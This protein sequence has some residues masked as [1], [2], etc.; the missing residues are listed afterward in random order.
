VVG[1]RRRG[2][3]QAFVQLDDGRGRVECAFFA[4]AWNQYAALLTRDRV[5]VVEG[6]LREDEFSGGFALRARRCWDYAQLCQ[7][8]AQRLS[9]KLDLREDEALGRFTHLLQGHAGATP[10]LVEAITGGAIG[11]LS[12]NGG[13]GVRSDAALPSLVRGLPGVRAVRLHLN[14]PW[15]Q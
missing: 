11:R 12:I 14:R 3:S 13:R 15:A 5:L 10:L 1:L 9:V 6:G 8:Q 7:Q 4:E 2:E